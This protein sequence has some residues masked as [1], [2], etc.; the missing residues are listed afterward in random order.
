M[1]V[2]PLPHQHQPDLYQRN[3]RIKDEG[4]FGGVDVILGLTKASGSLDENKGKTE[5]QLTVEQLETV[6]AVLGESSKG[7][8]KFVGKYYVPYFV[9]MKKRNYVEPFYYYV[10]RSSDN[11]EVKKWLD[12]HAQRVNEFLAWSKQY[13]WPKVDS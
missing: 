3:L 5:A 11:P 13:Q 8:S 2:K 9:E 7:N 4:D 10:S 12:E 1:L 6:F